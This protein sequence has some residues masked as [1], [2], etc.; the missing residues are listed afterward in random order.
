MTFDEK[1]AFV[2]LADPDK[3]YSEAMF[4]TAWV[5]DCIKKGKVLEHDTPAYRLRRTNSK[6]KVPF[7]TQDDLEL[8]KYIASL[9]LNGSKNLKGNRIYHHFASVVSWYFLLI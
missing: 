1:H 2:K 3:S 6:D 8:R 7:T 4:S 5:D 9:K